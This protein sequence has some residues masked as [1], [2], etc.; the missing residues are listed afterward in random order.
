MGQV[1]LLASVRVVDGGHL[2][3]GRRG[4]WC[5]PWPPLLPCGPPTVPPG[6]P[7]PRFRPI[8]VR[9]WCTSRLQDP[10]QKIRWMDNHWAH[11]DGGQGS[12]ELV[13]GSIYLA[14]SVRN[15]GSGLAVPIGWSVSSRAGRCRGAARRSQLVSDA[16]PGSLHRAQRRRLLACRHPGDRRP[17]LRMVDQVTEGARTLHDRTALWG[18]RGR[19]AHDQPIRDDPAAVG[20]ETRWY[21]SVARHWNLDRPDPR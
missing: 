7:R 17:R 21:P 8:S 19:P 4:P 14:I 2:G 6:W 16:D 10:M 18:P 1:P 12:A 20:D 9:C 3:H 11:L 5:L 15:V 13:D